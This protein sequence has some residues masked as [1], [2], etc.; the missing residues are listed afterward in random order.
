MITNPYI[1]LGG[2]LG[3][4]TLEMKPLEAM[5]STGIAVA[6]GGLSILGKGLYDRI[7]AEQKVCEK[8]LKKAEK[9]RRKAQKN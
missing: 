7:T 3:D 1:R 5:T 8:A 2:T 4:P 6:T 9:R